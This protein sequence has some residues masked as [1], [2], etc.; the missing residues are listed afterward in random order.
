MRHAISLAG[1]LLAAFVIF[2]VE[3]AIMLGLG[4]V[5]I[6]RLSGRWAAE[7][8]LSGV[9]FS[10][11]VTGITLL[12]LI[13]ALA[14]MQRWRRKSERD[15][16]DRIER[17]TE[18]WLAL[19]WN[20]GPNEPRLDGKRPIQ[21]MA[22]T[23]ALLGLRENLRGPDSQRIAQLY[24]RSGLLERDL[25]EVRFGA[26]N[27]RAAA[28]ERL[29][30]IRHPKSLYDLD[31]TAGS[32]RHEIAHMALFALARVSARLEQPVQ[33]LRYRFVP[34]LA[35]TTLGDGA[36]A[37]LLVLLERNAEP[38][39]EAMLEPGSNHPR[40]KAALN[41]LGA[42]R[43]L[44]LAIL[45]MPWLLHEAV[46][47]RASAA[48]ALA[49]IGFVPDEAEEVVHNLMYDPEW[50]VRSQA[51]LAAAWLSGRASEAKILELLGDPAWWVRHNAGVSL[52]SRGKRGRTLLEHAIEAHPDR[53]GRDMAR[54][55]LL[56]L[57]GEAAFGAGLGAAQAIA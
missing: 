46:D 5:F 54:Q 4:V 13:G 31:R 10:L 21:D 7:L 30:L 28:I 37:Q 33:A 35:R 57:D 42:S 45:T 17:W 25:R 50:P 8:A 9:L 16:N 32:G 26:P 52:M 24:E 12:A 36:V 47:M 20:E 18:V 1:Y 34:R 51:V 38:V 6:N 14:L 22:A 3:S 40:I 43:R 29:S 27:T 56:E 11:M 53:F 48:R 23:K 2:C 19:V 55:I 49:R 44:D 41:A 15:F 39:L